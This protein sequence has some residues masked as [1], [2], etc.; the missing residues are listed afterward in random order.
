MK[1]EKIPM[2]FAANELAL[3]KVSCDTSLLSLILHDFWM[4]LH[5]GDDSCVIIDKKKSIWIGIV[6]R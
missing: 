2:K 6:D 4:E 1:L 5:A 3:D